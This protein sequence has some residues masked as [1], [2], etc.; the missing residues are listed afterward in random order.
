M[1]QEITRLLS[2]ITYAQEAMRSRTRRVSSV[3]E[4]G[5]FILTEVDA[6]V[7]EGLELGSTISGISNEPW[8]ALKKPPLEESVP[9][10]SL[11]K[12]KPWVDVSASIDD[13]PKMKEKISLRAIDY[14]NPDEFCVDEDS[15]S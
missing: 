12:L 15:K 10:P 14:A 1:N 7:I 4:H 8:L 9:Y 6:N 2:L 11:P 3:R 13:K 5:D